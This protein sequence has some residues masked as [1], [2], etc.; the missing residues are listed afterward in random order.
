MLEPDYLIL[1]SI[2][3][4]DTCK[5]YNCKQSRILKMR[6]HIMAISHGDVVLKEVSIQTLICICQ[7]VIAKR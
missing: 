5:Y 3:I 2:T 7:P 4:P 1:A 6:H